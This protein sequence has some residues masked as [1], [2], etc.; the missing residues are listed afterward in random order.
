[1]ERLNCRVGSTYPKHSYQSVSSVRGKITIE[2][3]R[4][5]WGWLLAILAGMML[6]AIFLSSC[7]DVAFAQSLTAS[8]YTTE[9]L[10]KDGQW[11]ITH[12]KMANG[13]LFQDSGFTCASC[14]YRLGDRLLISRGGK[15]VMVTVTDRTNKRFKGKRID[16]TPKVFKILSPSGSLTEG[17]LKVE[18]THVR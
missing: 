16:L 5:T 10:I 9:G 11:A 17:L 8:Y 4:T 13:R 2:K 12:G 3:K 18:V 1:M 14:D 7:E 15:S 6:A